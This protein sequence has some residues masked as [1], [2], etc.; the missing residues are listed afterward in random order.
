VAR[1]QR[2]IFAI[3][4]TVVVTL[5][6]GSCFYEFRTYRNV[7]GSMT[8]TLGLGDRML[9]HRGENVH[10]GDIV[11]F[12]YPLQPNV[13]FAKRVVGVAGDIVEIRD[14]QLVRNGVAIAEPY[15]EHVDPQTFPKTPAL[16]EPYRSRDQFGPFTVPPS[17][18]FVLG[19]NRDRSSDSRYWGC[20][21]RK[22]IVGVLVLVASTRRGFWR[23]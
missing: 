9:F 15:A 8:P 13:V 2:Q 1:D 10:R 19:D 17:E 7:T 6:A 20:V 18:Y 5:V 16:P 22:N 21:P 12:R 3:A 23:P 14:K 11:A 4:L